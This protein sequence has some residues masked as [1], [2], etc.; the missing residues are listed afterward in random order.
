M[1]KVK[2]VRVNLNL[3]EKLVDRVNNLSKEMGLNMTATYIFL[4]NKAFD[5]LKINKKDNLWFYYFYY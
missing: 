5:Y 3:P 1:S 2:L 4:L